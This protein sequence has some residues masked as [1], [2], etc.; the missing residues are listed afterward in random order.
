MYRYGYYY[1]MTFEII[2]YETGEIEFQYQYL[3][4]SGQSASVGI[5]DSTGTYGSEYS[6]NEYALTESLAI[7]FDQSPLVV[8]PRSD[9]TASWDA[10][11][12][13]TLTI[14][15]SQAITDSFDLTYY[16]DLGWTVALLDSSMA[17]LVDNNLNGYPDTGDLRTGR[18]RD[19]LRPGRC[20][21]G[22]PPRPRR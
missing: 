1:Y 18:V 12:M 7:L 11:A 10:T 13:H 17:P 5:E 16:S 15:N 4:W 9:E 14:G 8:T 3:D 22:S 21:R 6:Y 20:A 2:L 19:I